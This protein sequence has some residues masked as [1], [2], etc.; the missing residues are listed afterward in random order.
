LLGAKC[1]EAKVDDDF[2]QQLELLLPLRFFGFAEN[3][4]V[5]KKKREMKKED[6]VTKM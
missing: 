5:R 2:L 4:N 6:E 1:G 3:K